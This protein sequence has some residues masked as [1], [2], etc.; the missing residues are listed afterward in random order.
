VAHVEALDAIRRLL[1]TEGRPELLQRARAHVVVGLTTQRVALYHRLGVVGREFDHA[2]TSPALGRHHFDGLFAHFA[3]VLTHQR[4]REIR[5]LHDD[6]GGNRLGVEV[7]VG[8]GV[9]QNFRVVLVH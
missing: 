7:H 8:H 5:P 9:F 1:E 3:Q 6:R 4:R 2:S